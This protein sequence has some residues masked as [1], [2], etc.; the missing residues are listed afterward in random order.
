MLT[1]I[2]IGFLNMYVGAISSDTD[3][4]LLCIVGL[5]KRGYRKQRKFAPG[6]K[7]LDLGS[8]SCITPMHSND[9]SL[10]LS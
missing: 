1:V 8:F 10:V 4:L 3:L 7:C 2:A 6:A 5:R 9:P